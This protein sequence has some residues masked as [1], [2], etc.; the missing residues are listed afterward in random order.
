MNLSTI[1]SAFLKHPLVCTDTRK[2]EQGCLFFCLKGPNFNANTFAE[3]ALNKGAAFVI[4]DEEK[5]KV[6]DRCILVDDVLLCIQQL[7]T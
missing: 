2:I 4:I 3:E 5:Y 1:Y 7:A 6:D